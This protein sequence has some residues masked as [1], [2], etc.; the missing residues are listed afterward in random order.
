MTKPTKWLCAQRR[1]RSA[2]VSTQSDQSLRCALNRSKDPS[3]LHAD[4]KDSDQTGRIPRLIWVFAGRTCHFVGFFTRR[5]I[6]K[7]KPILWN[8][9]Y[10]ISLIEPGHAKTCLRGFSTRY[11][12]N[13]PAQLQKLARIWNFGYSKYT[14]HTISAANNNGADKNA[15]MRRLICAFVVRI[16][17]KTRFR[18]TW[19]IIDFLIFPRVLAALVFTEGTLKCEPENMKYIKTASKLFKRL[20]T[21]NKFPFRFSVVVV[22][23]CFFSILIFFF[24]FSY[25]VWKIFKTNINKWVCCFKPFLVLPRSTVI[26]SWCL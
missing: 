8:Q 23:F 26:I 22:V 14:Y 17:H 25:I 11:V 4:S 1:L 21:K 19:P 15:R 10:V 9:I 18:M 13:Q 6:I 16:W 3:F 2:W 24:F 5:L 12:S 7:N 20:A